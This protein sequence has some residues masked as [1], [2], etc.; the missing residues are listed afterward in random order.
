[1]GK[2]VCVVGS[3]LG[4]LSGALRLA[5]LGFKVQLFE[6]NPQLGGKMSE[7]QEK[8]FRF[9]TGPSLLTMPFVVDELFHAIGL[10]RED[11][12]SF[13]AID[14]ICKYFFQD[15][16]T[17]EASSDITMMQQEIE[18]KFTGQ[19]KN[20]MNYL[21]YT[22]KIYETAAEVFLFTPLHEAR[23]L[24]K[25]KHLPLL[26]KSLQI[27]PWR[28]V[29]RSIRGFFSD[30][31]LIQIFNRYP[32]YN[33]SDPFRA[34][35]TLNIISYVEHEM[36]GYYIQNGMY[37]LVRVLEK[38]ASELGIQIYK[39]TR[40]D[41]IIHKDGMVSGLKVAQETIKCHYLLCGADVIESYN[42]L[43]D[44][45]SRR[46]KQLNRLEPS[47]SGMVFLWGL[48]RT[49][50]E[51]NLHNIIFSSDYESEFRQ[52]FKELKAP[53]DP[54]IYV[55]ISAKID[56]NHASKGGE[57]WF[58]LVNMP[59]ITEEQDWQL[60]SQ[61]MREIVLKK[62]KQFGFDIEQH[63]VVE[64]IMNP[65]DLYRL[66]A[67]NRGSIYGISS[68]S[69]TTA[70]RRPPN[71]NR[72]LKGLYF[73]GGSVHPGGGIPL[74]LLSGKMSAELIAEAEG[75]SLKNTQDMAEL[76]RNFSRLNYQSMHN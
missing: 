53:D 25:L 57:N 56:R 8:D 4:A 23:K 31:H 19:A 65:A 1:M 69:K 27:D 26:F 46:T 67:S 21:A 33:G 63:I 40:V 76:S 51:L 28:N 2:E 17:F 13:R 6:K 18:N 50:P 30:R 32:T 22:G 70:F 43:I 64:K 62:L 73:A 52:I 72:D 41:K 10:K 58:V 11:Y 74:V 39:N 20:Y 61:R 35:A 60:I 24:L 29:D 44:G 48:N 68:N 7:Y 54:T 5:Y 15:G 3:G 42:T 12:L 34:P 71:R 14:P 9:D 47:L 55:S 59:Y 45:Y 66:Y 38:I 75:V 49:Y 36:G 37:Q 16:V